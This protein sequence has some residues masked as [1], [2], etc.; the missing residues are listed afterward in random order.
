MFAIGQNSLQAVPVSMAT[1]ATNALV[2]SNE[3][4]RGT[5]DDSSVTPA[6]A[7]TGGGSEQSTAEGQD[8]RLSSG[9]GSKQLQDTSSD[10][11]SKATVA[12]PSNNYVLM[13]VC[14]RIQKCLRL[15]QVMLS[16]YVLKP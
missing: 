16:I 14:R 2:L 1:A 9:S 7:S 10:S 5:V 15:H 3:G 6:T 11:Y 12:T 4:S 8:S 13:H